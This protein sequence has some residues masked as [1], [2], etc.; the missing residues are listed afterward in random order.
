VPTGHRF[1][2]GLRSIPPGTSA[3]VDSE[4]IGDPP[5]A[6]PRTRTT[7]APSHVHISNKEK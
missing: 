1:D 5:E 7:S 3:V 6:V 2:V 4:V